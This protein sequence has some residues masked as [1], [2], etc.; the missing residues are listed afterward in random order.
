M[1]FAPAGTSSRAA[2]QPR[3]LRLHD[4]FIAAGVPPNPNDSGSARYSRTTPIA[5]L[6]FKVSP[7][8]NVY[9]NIGRG[10]ETPTFAELAY[11]TNGTSGLNFALR[12]AVSKHAEL[13]VKS[14]IGE[15]MRLNVALFRV[16]VTDEIAVF[17]NSGGRSTFQ[18]VPGT[19]RDGFEL[20]WDGRFGYGLEAAVA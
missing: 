6:T 15:A 8:V 10:F 1:N 7:A 5:G 16:D 3:R 4:Y 12:P 17:S 14:R 19:R 13:G 20:A 11:R 2:L 18:N 9:G